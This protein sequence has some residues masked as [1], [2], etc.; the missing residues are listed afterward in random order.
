[1]LGNA[2][3][4]TLLCSD[5]KQYLSRNSVCLT[6]DGNG[7]AMSSVRLIPSAGKRC[8][9]YFIFIMT[10]F[11]CAH[12]PICERLCPT[13]CTH[14]TGLV[15]RSHNEPFPVPAF[16]QNTCDIPSSLFEKQNKI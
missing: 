16:G 11:S 1:M 4:L 13:T 12:L 5:Q 3:F 6:A 10:V 15:V 8:L 2:E 9:A 7:R 14:L